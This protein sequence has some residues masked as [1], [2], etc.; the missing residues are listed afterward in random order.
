[1]INNFTLKFFLNYTI[2][3]SHYFTITVSCY[4]IRYI[5]KIS[6]ISRD[7][8]PRILKICS[9]RIYKIY[10]SQNPTPR[11]KIY[12]TYLVKKMS[13]R[14]VD[15]KELWMYPSI[16]IYYIPTLKKKRNKKNYRTKHIFVHIFLPI[17]HRYTY[18][19]TRWN[20]KDV[21]YRPI[22]RKSIFFETNFK[23]SLETTPLKKERKLR[24]PRRIVPL[25]IR[26]ISRLIIQWFREQA[27]RSKND[28]W[29]RS[30]AFDRATL[31][32]GFVPRYRFVRLHFPPLGRN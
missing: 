23:F 25:Y 29:P 16:H 12:F 8:Y 10:A 9:R 14:N 13:G 22:P 32:R 7:I 20:V 21:D 24:F 11:A 17:T 28:L 19:S 27:N 2:L 3:L 4:F 30:V 26:A 15:G 1:M 18:K 31:S 5:W 6:Q